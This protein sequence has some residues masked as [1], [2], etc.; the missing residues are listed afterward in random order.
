MGLPAEIQ[1]SAEC[2][3]P[4]DEGD[5]A[6]VGETPERLLQRLLV[7]A[8]LD[9]GVDA[10]PARGP[11]ELEPDVLALRVEGGVCASLDGGLPALLNGVYDGD[12]RCAGNPRHLGGYGPY[13]PEAEDGDAVTQP[14]VAVAD[15]A[16]GKLRGVQ[17][18]GALPR[19]RY[20]ELTKIKPSPM[21]EAYP[22]SKRSKASFHI[23]VGTTSV[24]PAGP[25]RVMMKM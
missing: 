14:D 25:P 2:P 24:A 15:A 11:L 4:S 17:T 6:A 22:A 8:G 19:F 9:R 5:D 7:T 12:V 1:G 13:R 20:R 16:E 23:R 21:A 18:Q 10:G 3:C